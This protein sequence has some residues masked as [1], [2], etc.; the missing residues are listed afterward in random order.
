MV[1][2]KSSSGGWD[3]GGSFRLE[4]GIFWSMGYERL[5]IG[6]VD[7]TGPARGWDMEGYS[8]LEDGIWEAGGWDMGGWRMGYGS[9][10]CS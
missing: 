8:R 10:D 3:F 6:V 9:L 5:E 1:R 4:D 2:A 7:S